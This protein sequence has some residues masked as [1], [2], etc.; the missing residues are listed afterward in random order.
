MSIFG[1]DTI[2]ESL[3]PELSGHEEEAAAETENEQYEEQETEADVNTEEETDP[4]AGHSDELL[5]GKYK[6]V[7]ELAKGYKNLEAQ[8]HKS[9]QQPEAQQ[10]Q[11]Q[12][13]SQETAEE[14][15]DRVYAAFN[16][17][18]AGTINYLVQQQ[19]QQALAPIQ[20]ERQLSSM[21]KNIEPIANE[22]AQLHTDEGSEQFFAKVREIADELGNPE[23]IRNPSQRVLRMAAT[24]LWGSESKSQIYDKAK[25]AGRIEAETSRRNKLGVAVSVTQKPTTTPKTEA[26]IIREGI[27]GAG[28][29]GGIFG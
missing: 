5:A 12:Q 15:N 8:F 27:L 14:F 23:L 9:R 17:D 25:E 18:P 11:Q 26:D 24:E 7:E 21:G 6:T 22:Y 29:R 1:D 19:L 20:Q 3:S 16:K 28:S 10:P 4:D 13:Q 2:P